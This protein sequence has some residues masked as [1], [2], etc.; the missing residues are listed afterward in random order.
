MVGILVLSFLI[1]TLAAFV[2]LIA[3]FGAGYQ[4]AVVPHR[5]VKAAR[6]ASDHMNG[7]VYRG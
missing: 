4:P 2:L 7:D 5:V 6:K 3:G 1:L